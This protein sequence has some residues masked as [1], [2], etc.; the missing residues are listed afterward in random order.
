MTQREERLIDIAKDLLDF[1]RHRGVLYSSDHQ[2]L[3]EALAQYQGECLS[4][5]EVA[6]I[7]QPMWTAEQEHELGNVELCMCAECR[8]LDEAFARQG[9][10]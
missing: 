2:E 6:E 7:L 10:R 9:A 3:E 8:A 1:D 4:P 5:L